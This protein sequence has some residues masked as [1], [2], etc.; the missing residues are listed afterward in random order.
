MSDRPLA[1]PKRQALIFLG[2]AMA[3][4]VVLAFPM[5]QV[6]HGKN[7][8]GSYW[9][10]NSCDST[11]SLLNAGLMLQA[12][13]APLL[14]F[15]LP[16]PGSIFWKLSPSPPV[17]R[18][19]ARPQDHSRARKSGLSSLGPTSDLRS[20]VAV[21]AAIIGIAGLFMFLWSGWQLKHIDFFSPPPS[22]SPSWLSLRS[23]IRSAAFSQTVLDLVIGLAGIGGAFYLLYLYLPSRPA[24]FMLCGWLSAATIPLVWWYA[25]RGYAESHGLCPA[26]FDTSRPVDPFHVDLVQDC[27]RYFKY[28]SGFSALW[29][30]V[31]A[32]G[33]RLQAARAAEGGDAGGELRAFQNFFWVYLLGWAV[34]YRLSQWLRGPT[35]GTNV[36]QE[37]ITWSVF[38]FVYLTASSLWALAFIRF[39]WNLKARTWIVNVIVLF[40]GSFAICILTTLTFFW[41]F[42]WASLALVPLFTL[43]VSGAAWALTVGTWRWRALQKQPFAVALTAAANHSG[44]SQPPENQ[45]ARNQPPEQRPALLGL[46]ALEIVAAAIAGFAI[47]GIVYGLYIWFFIVNH[48]QHR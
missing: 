7:A 34:Q 25:L 48:S 9:L 16:G 1:S 35:P 46:R 4:S 38:C 41:A 45:P 2:I 32:G 29:M 37:W 30:G 3:V 28:L 31:T 20:L 27:Q 39:F 22:A 10:Q 15:L 12:T 47:L 19:L 21:V 18:A 42:L 13:L 11:I 33:L 43:N 8:P 40:A 44:P 17:A 14:V 6:T 36:E 26:L 23:T 5:E 24:L